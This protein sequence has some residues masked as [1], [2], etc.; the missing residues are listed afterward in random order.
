MLEF[1]KIV[2]ALKSKNISLTKMLDFIASLGPHFNLDEA[3]EI[4]NQK[5]ANEEISKPIAEVKEIEFTPEE[6]QKVRLLLMK[7]IIEDIQ[8]DISL[9]REVWAYRASY[10]FT[11]R[12]TG[13]E[14]TDSVHEAKLRIDNLC[15]MLRKIANNFGEE[16]TYKNKNIHPH[17]SLNLKFT[18]DTIIEN[19]QL[20]LSS[21]KKEVG[22]KKNYINTEN[23]KH[24]FKG[25]TNLNINVE[26]MYFKNMSLLQVFSYFGLND[27]IDKAVIFGA[28]ID[29]KES[30]TGK[31]AK[32]FYSADANVPANYT[33]YIEALLA[34]TFEDGKYK[35]LYEKKKLEQH[36][37]QEAVSDVRLAKSNK[38]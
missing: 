20:E 32:E 3:I 36:L 9:L 14:F 28:D 30:T 24:Y 13:K 2:S 27:L 8:R 23:N 17:I 29:Y 33:S 15:P 16:L 18:P 19:I 10:T 5:K 38:I 6:T 37:G 12:D 22:F 31:T 34:G 26:A 1:L 35:A 11:E 25:M 4:S 7:D 21:Y